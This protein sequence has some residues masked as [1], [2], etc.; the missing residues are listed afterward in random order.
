MTLPGTGARALPLGRAAAAGLCLLLACS[1]PAQAQQTDRLGET[2]RRIR[3]EREALEEALDRVRRGQTSVLEVL[4]GIEA[5]LERKTRR[6]ET[7]DSLLQRQEREL[8]R[9]VKAAGEAAAALEQG[10][11]DLAGRVR[12]L[13]RWR[14]AGTPFVLLN[15]DFSG[16][17]LMRRKRFLETV[18]NRDRE[19]VRGLSRDARRSRDL[20]KDVDARRRKLSGERDEE[21]ALR[22]GLRDERA[23]QRRRLAALGKELQRSRRRLD[24]LITEAEE[25][26]PGPE[27][28]PAGDPVDETGDTGADTARVTGAGRLGIPVRGRIVSRFGAHKHPELDLEVHRPGIDIAAPAGAE[29]RAMDRG[30]VLAVDRMSGYGRVL[31][32]DHGRGYH[33][34]YGRL[35]ELDKA[36]GDRVERG[37][38]IAWVGE[39]G[40]SGESRLYFEMRKNRKPVDPFPRSG[41]SARGRRR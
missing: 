4:E 29:V 8:D 18:L 20:R 27:P 33:T 3:Q 25:K 19:L 13:Y 9:A 1:W 38:R 35:S 7:L 30:K 14:R 41:R 32:I 28:D 26:E 22:A 5:D 6:L 21:A 15:G 11:R 24:R 12:A 10:R 36:K 34:V 31:V 17:E 23:R 16:P 2:E 40:S 39:R 37:E